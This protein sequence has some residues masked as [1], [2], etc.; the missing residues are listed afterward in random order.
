MN[1]RFPVDCQ[2]V[3]EMLEE[4]QDGELTAEVA[5]NLQLHLNACG[6]CAASL[7][8]LR[9]E[10]DIYRQYRENLSQALNID[11]RLWANV[12]AQLA[13]SERESTARRPARILDRIRVYL[14]SL[15][16]GNPRL[17]VAFAAGLLVVLSVGGTLTAVHYFKAREQGTVG[18]IHVAAGGARDLESA[19]RSI[20]HAEQEYLQAI[21]VLSAIVDKRKPSLD[22]ALMAELESNL[23]AIDE[24]IAATRRAYLAHPHDPELAHYMLAA[25]SKKVELL[26]DL[27][28]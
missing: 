17:R 15:H 16:P 10:E 11:P 28:S 24:S 20:Q 1:V 12:Q 25:Y 3:Q 13:A 18:R 26:L 14:T 21:G 5:A 8:R 23:R 2:R 27:A 19:L 9:A 22:A 7:E 6:A 4:F